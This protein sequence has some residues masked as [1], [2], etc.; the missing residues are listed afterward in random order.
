VVVS[1]NHVS[2]RGE[3]FHSCRCRSTGRAPCA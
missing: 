1:V 2:G 3:T